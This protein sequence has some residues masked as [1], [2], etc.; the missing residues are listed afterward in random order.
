MCPHGSTLAACEANRAGDE[1]KRQLALSVRNQHCCST[2]Q[3]NVNAVAACDGRHMTVMEWVF[4]NG[5][6][7]VHHKGRLVVGGTTFICSLQ[8]AHSSS[9]DCSCEGTTV[10]KL[11]CRL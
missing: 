10:G 3:L 11:C 2:S 1:S 9:A 4:V 5:I 8:I 6:W 7:N